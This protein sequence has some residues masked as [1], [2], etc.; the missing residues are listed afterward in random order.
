MQ[1]NG[2]RPA[3]EQ[4]RPGLSEKEAELRRVLSRRC[5]RKKKELVAS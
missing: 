3:A 5:K 4:Q 1:Q 2:S